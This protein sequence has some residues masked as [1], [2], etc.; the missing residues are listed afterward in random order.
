[1]EGD[2]LLIEQKEIIAN[3]IKSYKDI[4]KNDKI[5][6]KEIV[7][8]KNGDVDAAQEFLILFLIENFYGNDIKFEK[9]NIMKIHFHMYQDYIISLD[10]YH[11]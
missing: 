5:T 10:G 11:N 8:A 3:C 9:R 2:V 1:M 6:F 4:T 7:K